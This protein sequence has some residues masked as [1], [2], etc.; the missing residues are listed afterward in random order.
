MAVEEG[1][2]D[3]LATLAKNTER[4]SGMPPQSLLCKMRGHLYKMRT[5]QKI[6]TISI[7]KTRRQIADL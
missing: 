7:M 5:R 3:Y 2:S 1:M 6:S 4:F